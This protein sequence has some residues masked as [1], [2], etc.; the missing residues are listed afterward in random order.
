MK[1]SSSARR[2]TRMAPSEIAEEVGMSNS[3]N[4]DCYW[5]SSRDTS[6]GEI[7][8]AERCVRGKFI[9]IP[10]RKMS[11]SEATCVKNN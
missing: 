7:G 10:Q 9:K 1:G 2:P 11:T 6:P 8:I 5:A 4:M 3:K